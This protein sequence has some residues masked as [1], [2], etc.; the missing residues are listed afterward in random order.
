MVAA[1]AEIGQ[2][3]GELGADF[4]DVVLEPA[5]E[6][7]SRHHCGF[8]GAND[9]PKSSEEKVNWARDRDTSD[10]SDCDTAPDADESTKANESPVSAWS[11]AV[12]MGSCSDR[13]EGDSG[14]SIDERRLR[15]RDRPAANEDSSSVGRS[16]SIFE[17]VL[18]L[19]A[20]AAVAATGEE[21]IGVGRADL[22]GLEGS[23]ERSGLAAVACDPQGLA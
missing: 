1:G 14:R 6:D 22:G 4:A 5:A 12:S 8:C 18:G 3:C 11:S 17:V 16:A 10:G 23:M 19:A 15:G 21:A 9:E 7:G 20:G 13:C 2:S